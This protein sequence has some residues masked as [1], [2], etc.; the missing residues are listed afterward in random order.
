MPPV[1]VR[2]G[3]SVT[4]FVPI[5]LNS[6]SRK[7]CRPSPIEVS[8]ITA[9]MPTAMPSSVST[10]RPRC[11][12]IARQAIETVSVQRIGAVLVSVSAQRRDSAAT[13]SSRAARRAGITPNSSPVPMAV[14]SAATTAHSG[15]QAGNCG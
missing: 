10:L 11:A 15:G 2:P 1:V 4:T 12:T 5:W 9:A 8:R 7:R 3:E 6:A 14:P 13:G